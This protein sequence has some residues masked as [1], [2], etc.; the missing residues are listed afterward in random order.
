MNQAETAQRKWFT[1]YQLAD[2]GEWGFFVDEECGRFY[3]PFPTKEK[4]QAEADNFRAEMEKPR[5]FLEAWKEAVLLIAEYSRIEVSELVS[6]DISTATSYQELSPKLEKWTALP[7]NCFGCDSGFDAL[8]CQVL[9]FY[10]SG[11]A[12]KSVD[13][14]PELAT[15]WALACLVDQNG[16]RVV[17]NLTKYY[18]GW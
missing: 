3:S 15:P 4:A 8:V 9:S 2:T 17:S 12:M 7:G 11:A 5:H 6:G 13:Y 18:C 1:P 14:R 16:K 10:N